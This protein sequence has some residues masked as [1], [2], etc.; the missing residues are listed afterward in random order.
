MLNQIFSSYDTTSIANAAKLFNIPSVYQLPIVNLKDDNGRINVQQFFYGDKDGKEFFN[1]FVNTFR[2]ADWRILSKQNW[3]EVSSNGATPITIYANRPLNEEAGLDDAAQK[4]LKDYLDSLNIYP[5]IVIHRGHS[6]YVKSSIKQIT[7][8]S[9]LVLLGSCGGYHSLSKVL[10]VSPRAQI[11]ASKQIGTGAI[12]IAIIET[13]LETL[14][15]D[16]DLNWQG[17]WKTVENKFVNKKELKDRFDDYI[18]PYKNLGA[19][20]IMAY[21]KAIEYGK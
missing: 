3:I 10:D 21:H 1:D 17:L 2:A 6:Y 13:I 15:Q 16:K 9:K 4:K 20:F 7:G 18:P 11:I 14:R 12:N 19:I 5:T 8:N